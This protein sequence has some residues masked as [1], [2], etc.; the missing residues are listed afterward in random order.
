MRCAIEISTTASDIPSI[1]MCSNKSRSSVCIADCTE[2]VY[3][4]C[5]RAKRMEELG[6]RR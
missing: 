4:N 3:E 1:P 6:L 5:I 2:V